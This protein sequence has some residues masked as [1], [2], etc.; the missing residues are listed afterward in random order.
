[1][2]DDLTGTAIPAAYRLSLAD[3]ALAAND[4]DEMLLDALGQV[5][6]ALDRTGPGRPVLVFEP[7]AGPRSTLVEI[8]VT[9]GEVGAIGYVLD[10]EERPL[11]FQIVAPPRGAPRLLV[12]LATRGAGAELLFL[13]ERRLDPIVP[14]RTRAEWTTAGIA[15]SAWGS[16]HDSMRRAIW[17]DLIAQISGATDPAARNLL[18]APVRL[19]LL[20]DRPR[21]YPA[22]EIAW[23]DHAAAP[24]ARVGA[25]RSITTIEQG[26]LRAAVRI[27]R[28]ALGSRFVETWRL[29]AGS[30]W[31]EVETEIDWRTRG[32]LLVA[33]VPTAASSATFLCDLGVGAAERPVAAERLYEVPAYRW[34]ALEGDSGAAGLALL[35]DERAGRSH[36]DPRTLRL[37]LLH[38]PATLRRFPHQATQDFGRHRIR[39]ALAPLD[40][41]RPA[42]A[43]NRLA[44]AWATP[45][46]A[47][48]AE[49]TASGGER[50]PRRA[51]LVDLGAHAASLL[52]VERAEGSQRLLL[53]LRETTG[54]SVAVHVALGERAKGIEDL[55]A[56]E[57]PR[58]PFRAN[59]A[60]ARIDPREPSH[61]DVELRPWS[62]CTL[63]F[64]LEATREPRPIGRRAVGLRGTLQGFSRDGERAPGG[65]DGVGRSFP[66][67]LTPLLLQHG[68]VAFD[69]AAVHGGGGVRAGDGGAVEIPPG[70]AEIWWLGAATSEQTLDAHFLLEGKRLDARFPSWRCRSPRPTG[71]CWAGS[72]ASGP[73]GGGRGA[74]RSPGSRPISTIGAVAIS[75]PNG[76]CSS[77]RPCASKAP[78]ASSGC[79][80]CP[81]CAWSPRRWSASP[82]DP[83][84]RRFRSSRSSTR[85][86][87]WPPPPARRGS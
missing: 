70:Y 62:L 39:W 56:T 73:A 48:A 2:H 55:D 9:A 24:R 79:R 61:A 66:L 27:E 53:R 23:E 6:R 45:P 26:P 67:E 69:L 47:L 35:C 21:K 16:T 74:S 1:M 29:A 14:A 75:R 13:C 50:G 41:E 63:A 19:E 18:S 3:E 60:P 59:D 80:G 7:H 20:P 43:A 31:L 30:P 82:R 37:T 28:E 22:W 15:S 83:W 33:S 65:F 51:P 87:S 12:A 25:P 32:A 11:P 49:P 36:P 4:F 44:E 71:A 10:A 81:T 5:A 34:S 58:D 76:G 86:S 52:A 57:R 77:R 17:Q 78:A 54:E 38:S 8:G 85:F 64:E 84:P 40:G 42:G 72:S 68:P 46:I